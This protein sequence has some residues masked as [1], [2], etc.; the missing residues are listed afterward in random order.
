MYKKYLIKK[1]IYR[2]NINVDCYSSLNYQNPHYFPLFFFKVAV[3]SD[4]QLR[5][6]V[7]ERVS[8]PTNWFVNSTPGG[9]FWHVGEELTNSTLKSD[10]K[11]IVLFVGTN[12]L[13]SHYIMERASAS[14][15]GLLFRAKKKFPT[16]K[17]SIQISE[18]TCFY[19][20]CM[21][22][23]HTGQ[24]MKLRLVR[25]F[26]GIETRAPE[27]RGQRE[28]GQRGHSTVPYQFLHASKSCFRRWN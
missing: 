27:P 25:L 3:F 2:K 6:L 28:S 18:L 16:T 21:L 26:T 4:S 14:F 11:V 7:E 1:R 20:I 10:P 12:D 13:S 15:R 5:P 23:I 8:I 19:L 24:Y 17:V 22:E 9:R